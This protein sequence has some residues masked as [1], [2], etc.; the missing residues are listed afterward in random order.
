MCGARFAGSSTTSLEL[1]LR[2]DPGAEHVEAILELDPDFRARYLLDRVIGAG[3]MGMVLLAREADGGRTVAIKFMRLL[4]H[5]ELADRFQREARLLMSVKHPNVVEL[6][7]IDSVAG[8]PVLV[9]EYL[10]GGTLKERLKS[11]KR[12]PPL[13]TVETML[14]VLAGL[15]ALHRTGV[16]HRDL[17]PDNVLFSDHGVPKIA[18][19]GIAKDYGDTALTATGQVL[20]T[21]IY[22]SPEQARGD[23][24]TVASDIY[25]IG[26]LLYELLSGAPP[27]ETL[28]PLE[29]IRLHQTT[30]PP[31][32][33]S[34]VPTVPPKL[35][36]V[37]HR[38]LAKAV[39]ER[40]AS[41]EDLCM[42]LERAIGRE[43]PL[44]LHD[45]SGTK[46][47]I[48]KG[49]RAPAS[50]AGRKPS[51]PVAAPAQ[52]TPAD[53]G[54]T[55]LEAPA[56]HKIPRS[57]AVQQTLIQKPV[58]ISAPVAYWTC[59]IND[60]A[61][62][63]LAPDVLFIGRSPG[64]SEMILDDPGV[65]YRHALLVPEHTELRLLDFR[66][67]NGIKVN[68]RQVDQHQLAEGD[69]VTLGAHR[70]TFRRTPAALEAAPDPEFAL[71]PEALSA[72]LETP[73]D[74]R[75]RFGAF[76]DGL[77]AAWRL[78]RAV[79]LAEHG[80]SGSFQTLAARPA[81]ATASPTALR[82]VP[83]SR[84]YGGADAVLVV[85]A[86][87]GTP[88]ALAALRAGAQVVGQLYIESGPD[89]PRTLFASEGIGTLQGV[90]SLAAMAV[91]LALPRARR[92]E[93]R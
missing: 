45:V 50:N 75:D 87:D 65:S 92:E 86:P 73:G 9:M 35:A 3:G 47:P 14:P 72:W 76:L 51:A 57:V 81:E 18:D 30:E 67:T 37:I 46:N 58:P 24:P 66:S 38:A 59:A 17:K 13:E 64:P 43:R 2:T 39:V 5:A 71:P 53:V 15:A 83:T 78:S 70:L 91:E 44:A 79:L 8:H 85:T 62:V 19:L 26:C 93:A 49:Y 84:L 12:L 29:L 10:G 52:P 41:C 88:A 82:E 60:R 4:E 36:A 27:F 74:T 80:P 25:A 55:Q 68:G 7:S 23:K 40:P 77:M 42:L 22:M 33:V 11:R 61:P 34:R 6:Y 1:A 56:A 28:N 54:R 89:T 90:A 48:L 32:L 63:L 20:G 16:I 21:P 69:V 31:P